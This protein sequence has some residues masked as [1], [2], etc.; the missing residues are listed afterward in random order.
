MWLQYYGAQIILE[1]MLETEI[2]SL[3]FVSNYGYENSIS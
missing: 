1:C 2:I 3:V